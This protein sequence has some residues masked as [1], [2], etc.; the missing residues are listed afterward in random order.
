MKEVTKTTL[1]LES[2]LSQCAQIVFRRVKSKI[3]GQHLQG[4][5]SNKDGYLAKQV[6]SYSN[7]NIFYKSLYTSYIVWTVQKW[8]KARLQ[9]S[10]DFFFER[11]NHVSKAYTKQNRWIKQVILR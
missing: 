2:V 3:W 11:Q 4:H 6:S 7:V 1:W 8:T 5:H 9:L 10:L